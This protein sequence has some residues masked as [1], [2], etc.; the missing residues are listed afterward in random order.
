LFE[1]HRR[2]RED[3]KTEDPMAYY[4]FGKQPMSEKDWASCSDPVAMLNHLGVAPT[5]RK[6][7]LVILAYLDRI[8]DLSV[9]GPISEWAEQAR[10]VT[11]GR[12][13]PDAFEASEEE[14]SRY[15]SS[16]RPGC[17]REGFSGWAYEAFYSLFYY[18]QAEED[19]WEPEMSP[20]QRSEL[21]VQAGFIRDIFGNPYCS[22][23]LDA[24][25]LTPDVVSI[26]QTIYEYQA[27][28]RMP[29]L[30]DTLEG[31]GC[32]NADILAHCRSETE[33]V[34][35]CWVLDAILDKL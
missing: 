31:A 23:T 14:A 9:P 20:E 28:D 2:C 7:L 11:V 18:A 21:E 8:W 25:W 17:L 3:K 34:L 4:T 1:K 15:L 12:G 29:S 27:F 35:G 6:C 33:H 16:C 13:E 5:D 10:L 26:A 22:V 24:A 32:D 19:E 30:G